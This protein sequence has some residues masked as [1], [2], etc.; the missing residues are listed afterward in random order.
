[1][2]PGVHSDAWLEEEK[3]PL[4]NGALKKLDIP[5]SV[6][7]KR[8]DGRA[9]GGEE[10]LEVLLAAVEQLQAGFIG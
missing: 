6:L 4:H 7:G 10:I 5:A 8:E 2:L 9:S 3:I 1:L